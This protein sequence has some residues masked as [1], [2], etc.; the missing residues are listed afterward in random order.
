MGPKHGMKQ[1]PSRRRELRLAIGLVLMVP[2]GA[3]HAVR[4]SSVKHKANVVVVGGG[5][6]GSANVKEL[7]DDNP[8]LSI[9]VVD[10][11]KATTQSNPSRDQRLVLQDSALKQLARVF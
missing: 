6:G 2:L 3:A 10:R 9:L 7:H 8:S 4:S 1:L 11:K 5:I